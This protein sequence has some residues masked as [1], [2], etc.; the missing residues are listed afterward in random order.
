VTQLAYSH[1]ISKSTAYD[2]LHK[3]R[4]RLG[5]PCAGIGISTARGEITGHAHISV[6]G[7]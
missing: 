1:T 6:D 5:G 7:P 3:G 2:Y 4:Q